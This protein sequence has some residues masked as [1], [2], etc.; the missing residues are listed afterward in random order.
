[1]QAKYYNSRALPA[2]E[3]QPG[4]YVWLL[5]R[6]IK[7]SRPSDKLDYRKLGPF[8]VVARK[9]SSAYHLR[10]PRTLSRLHPVFN[11]SLLEPYRGP[12]NETAP[13]LVDLDGDAT[14]E[15]TSVLDSRKMG[16]RYDYLV[17]W[18]DLPVSEN[19]WVPHSDLPSTLDEVLER[20]HR[21]HPTL[22]RPHQFDISR[23]RSLPDPTQLVPSSEAPAPTESSTSPT[24]PSNP[25]VPFTPTRVPSP[26][27]PL[28][29]V[30]YAPPTKTTLRSGRVSRPPPPR[31]DPAIHAP[32][33]ARP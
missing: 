23:D 26:L 15:V 17:S 9:G 28:R 7:T 6:N 21:R 29:T 27:Q 22:P 19:S 3:Y 2:P 32:R 11:V 13:M 25:R 10:L 31:L 8:P 1:M 20:F 30:G 12:S 16:R 24:I 18:K 14:P 33:R 4:D 5:R